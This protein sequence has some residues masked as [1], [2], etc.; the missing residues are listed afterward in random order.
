MPD[1]N[2]ELVLD[3]IDQDNSQINFYTSLFDLSIENFYTNILFSLA[4]L[5]ALDTVNIG[6]T[7]NVVET[8]LRDSNYF[9][10]LN[11]MINEGY[12]T[13]LDNEIEVLSSITNKTVSFS[14]ATMS[15]LIAKK[16]IDL[17]Q[18]NDIT[19]NIQNK[20]SV[21]LY[22]YYQGT[23]DLKTLKENLT[24]FINQYKGWTNTWIDTSLSGFKREASISLMKDNGIKKVKYL[25]PRDALTRDFCNKYAGQ[26]KTFEEWDKLN[27]GQIS[28]VSIYMGGY[29][30]RGRWLVV[31]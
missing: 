6:L 18:F 30:C 26:V 11:N 25:N 19:R 12:Q 31:E 14:D 3:Q 7:N 10:N 20:M 13:I 22:N 24:D 21:N 17:Q 9:N 15:N 28:P 2:E 8:A 23:I 4:A 16:E 29:N 5:R 1:E 27:N